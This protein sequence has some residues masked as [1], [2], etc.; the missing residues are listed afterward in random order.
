MWETHASWLHPAMGMLVL[1]L[2][3]MTRR[4]LAAGS[5][6]AQRHWRVLMALKITVVTLFQLTF[7]GR[8]LIET[9]STVGFPATI[10]GLLC[11]LSAAILYISQ[12][13][14][15]YAGKQAVIGR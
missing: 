9:Q 13:R 10:F 12:I 6:K 11:C 14:G 7:I 15:W 8:G 2:V 1:I 5:N 3:L 4:Q